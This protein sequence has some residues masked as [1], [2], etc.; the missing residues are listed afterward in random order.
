MLEKGLTETLTTIYKEI[1]YVRCWIKF[2]YNKHCT[3]SNSCLNDNEKKK[4]SR[5]INAITKI[6][7]LLNQNNREIYYFLEFLTLH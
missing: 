6:S 1:F 5:E 4:D 3:Y 7:G 2:I